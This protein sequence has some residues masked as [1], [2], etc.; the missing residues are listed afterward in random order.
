MGF[1]IKHTDRVI[2]RGADIKQLAIRA[3]ADAT[4]AGTG[5]KFTDNLP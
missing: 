3:E 1:G 4:R 5:V 2:I